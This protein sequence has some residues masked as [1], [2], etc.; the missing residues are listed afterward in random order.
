MRAVV[1]APLTSCPD[2]QDL[3]MSIRLSWTTTEI[4][5]CLPHECWDKG[6]HGH[7]HLVCHLKHLDMEMRTEIKLEP[8]LSPLGV[9]ASFCVWLWEMYFFKTNKDGMK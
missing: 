5:L 9:S 1:C 4:R 3:G 6:V 8:R 7:C 2:V